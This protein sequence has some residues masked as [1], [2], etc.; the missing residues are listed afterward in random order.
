MQTTRSYAAFV[1][2]G[3]R[4][5]KNIRRQMSNQIRVYLNESRY[6][7]AQGYVRRYQIPVA[8]LGRTA[9]LSIYGVIATI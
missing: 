7:R 4:K 6:I 1:A 2:L 8:V 5:E 3:T 9:V